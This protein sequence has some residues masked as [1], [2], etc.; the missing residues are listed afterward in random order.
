VSSVISS[1]KK[2]RRLELIVLA[3]GALVAL[4]IL[5]LG[6]K[7]AYRANMAG[8][9]GVDGFLLTTYSL[10][11]LGAVVISP[12]AVLA[13]LGKLIKRDGK[14]DFFQ[15]AGL[16]I[17]ILVTCVSVYLYVDAHHVSTHDRSSTAGLVI[18]AVPMILVLL[19][20]VLYGVLLSM[21][22]RAQKQKGV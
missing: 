12:Y 9:H 7:S 8:G 10:V 16:I 20:G 11:I 19:A 17:S 22:F 6:T 13:F 4:G 18:I 21:Y 15:I 5:G 3:A 14:S 2:V 1:A